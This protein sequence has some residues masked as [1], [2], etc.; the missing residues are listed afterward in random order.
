MVTQRGAT[1]SGR[2]KL[3]KSSSLLEMLQQSQQC[4]IYYHKTIYTY[5]SYISKI[6]CLSLKHQFSMI[7]SSSSIG[8]LVTHV[9]TSPSIGL[10]NY[11]EQRGTLKLGEK[12][13]SLKKIT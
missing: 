9:R 1:T 6:S 8:L 13:V 2:V 4:R 5:I 3:I 10:L 11:I 7:G 12:E